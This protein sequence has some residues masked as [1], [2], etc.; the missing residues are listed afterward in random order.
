MILDKKQLDHLVSLTRIEL[1]LSEEKKILKDLREILVHF[2][3]LETIDTS[4]VS[5]MVGGTNLKNILRIDEIG[6]S[7]EVATLKESFPEEKDGF[8][9]TPLIFE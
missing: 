5:K 1:D 2:E 4:S 8:L 6:A 9:K 7:D 3:E